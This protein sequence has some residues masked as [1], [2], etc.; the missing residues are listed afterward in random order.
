[1]LFD[2][3]VVIILVV[4]V[5]NEFG[6][7][8]R[9]VNWYRKQSEGQRIVGQRNYKRYIF[10]GL[11]GAVFALVI[12][13]TQTLREVNLTAST[14]ALQHLSFNAEVV[15]DSALRA[16][17]EVFKSSLD[18]SGLFWAKFIENTALFILL[19][20]LISIANVFMNDEIQ[21]TKEELDKV[22]EEDSVVPQ[23]EEDMVVEP[24]ENV[25]IE[26]VVVED[27]AVNDEVSDEEGVKNSEEDRTDT[28][29][30]I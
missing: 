18:F 5:V 1:M 19:P 23:A 20:I 11:V 29:Y 4:L 6:L 12:A 2:I 9:F 25:V 16:Q 27:E 24:V 26:E 7:R 3:I 14:L 8:E 15:S 10:I 30:E 28:D 22:I 17:T 13:Y 21:H